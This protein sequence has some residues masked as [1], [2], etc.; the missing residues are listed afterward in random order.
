MDEKTVINH[1]IEIKERLKENTLITKSVEEQAKRT[2]GRV[3]KLEEHTV[4]I[5]K[6]LAEQI[7]MNSKLD[8]RILAHQQWTE[9]KIKS[10][11]EFAD[12]EINEL[13]KFHTEEIE[14]DKSLKLEKEGANTKIKLTIWGTISTGVIALLTYLF[15]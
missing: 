2:N 4:E 10:S 5:D 15:K 6:I 1:L 8:G 11:R 7:H 12:R 14:L 9:E 13:K 3:S